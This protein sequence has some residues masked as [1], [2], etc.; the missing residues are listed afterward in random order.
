MVETAL[1][2]ESG[3][4]STERAA[5]EAE[6]RTAGGLSRRQP[7]PETSTGSNRSLPATPP[8]SVF[9]R[10]SSGSLRCAPENSGSHATLRWREMDSNPRSPVRRTT[11]F[12]T[13]LSGQ[14]R[15]E[16]RGGAR[17]IQ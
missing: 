7:A 16:P 14:T 3:S 10:I 17:L 4:L 12:E 1:D 2:L 11:V 9:D 15:R 5:D 8:A 6:D 13:L